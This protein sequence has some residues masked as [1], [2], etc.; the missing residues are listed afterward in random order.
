MFI[1]SADK[2]YIFSFQ[3]KVTDKNI[4]RK[5]SAG[6]VT[7]MYG[8]IGIRQCGGDGISGHKVMFKV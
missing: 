6:K 2:N 8:A 4:S 1:R 5:I 7:Y 3:T